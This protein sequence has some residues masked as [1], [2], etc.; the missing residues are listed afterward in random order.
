MALPLTPPVKPQLALTRKTLPE[1][2]EWAYEPK[3][4]GFRGLAFV[5]GEDVFLQ[6]RNGRPLL[7]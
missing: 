4:D 3:Y 6:S 1:G 5:D 2:D 7:R